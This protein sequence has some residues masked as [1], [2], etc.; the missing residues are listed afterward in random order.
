MVSTLVQLEVIAMGD[1][2]KSLSVCTSPIDTLYF[3]LVSLSLSK[4][5][6]YAY[7]AIGFIS[8]NSLKW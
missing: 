1:C 8:S 2:D 4:V 5:H 3:V 7:K 6:S